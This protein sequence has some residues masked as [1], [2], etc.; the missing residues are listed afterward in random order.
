ML[1]LKLIEKVKSE[2]V[3]WNQRSTI[4]KR[5]VLCTIYASLS[6]DKMLSGRSY[7]QAIRAH[8]L[9]HQILGDLILEYLDSYQNEEVDELLKNFVDGISL[10]TKDILQN[11]NL[12]CLAQKI[13]DGLTQ[14]AERGGTAALWVQYFRMVTSEKNFII[15]ERTAD[16][17]LHLRCVRNMIAYFYAT[18]HNLYAKCSHL[19]LQDM[20][21]LRNTM[22]ET[23]YA[24]FIDGLFTIRR[25]ERVW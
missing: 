13:E 17:Y 2:P 23:Q 5:C 25:S 24:T 20:L 18:G 9:V 6:F 21:Q 7:A 16:W 10:H 1:K 11:K 14:L 22:N 8:F 3:L 19:Y 15:A 4:Y 12:Q